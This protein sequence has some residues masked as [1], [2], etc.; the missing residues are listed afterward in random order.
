MDRRVFWEDSWRGSELRIYAEK[1]NMILN[2][3]FPH[4]P[5]YT[6]VWITDVHLQTHTSAYTVWNFTFLADLQDFEA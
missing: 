5:P 3:G 4:P 1:N 6:Y 2:T